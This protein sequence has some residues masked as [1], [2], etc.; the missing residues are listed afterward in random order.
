MVQPSYPH[1]STVHHL[2]TQLHDWDKALR[3]QVLDHPLWQQAQASR[4]RQDVEWDFKGQRRVW[5][6]QD[7]QA[8][9]VVVLQASLAEVALQLASRRLVVHQVLDLHL[10]SSLQALA[11]AFLLEAF[12]ADKRLMISEEPRK[13]VKSWS[14]VWRPM[15]GL[16][17]HA[18]SSRIY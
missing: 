11:E 18:A 3:A 5:V 1:R 14:S 2:Q 13:R 4:S 17:V 15:R 8:F 9:L 6:V 10:D 7:S 12:L 16:N